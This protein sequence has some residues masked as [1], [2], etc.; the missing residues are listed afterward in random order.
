[1]GG[2]ANANSFSWRGREV[3]LGQMRTYAN[4]FSANHFTSNYY[5]Y[6]YYYYF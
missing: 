2:N 6:Y 3:Y 5:Y 1:M 4:S